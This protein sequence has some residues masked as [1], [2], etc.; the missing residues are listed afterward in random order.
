ME[1]PD[2]IVWETAVSKNGNEYR[3]GTLPGG[4]DM[5]EEA[6]AR[7]KKAF[8]IAVNWPVGDKSWKTTSP[9]V[10]TTAA[11]THYRLFWK[12]ND[13]SPYILWFTNTEHY[14]YYFIDET[15]D[16]YGN[17]TFR[18][19]NHYIEYSSVKPNI[20]CIKGS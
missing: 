3:V 11:I 2:G 4:N 6:S 15:G 14:H 7:S 12:G 18:N 16:E 8:A 1:L 5:K 13:I 20:I 19:G 10:Q 9:D 17:N